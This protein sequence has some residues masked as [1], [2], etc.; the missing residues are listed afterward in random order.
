MN[1]TLIAIFVI[2]ILISIDIFMVGF[3]YGVSG[4]KIGKSRLIIISAIGN[5]IVGCA[6]VLGFMISNYIT[7]IVDWIAF[8]L[9]MLIGLYKLTDWYISRKAKNKPQNKKQTWKQTITLA[10]ILAIDGLGA[11]F[12]VGF[13]VTL[14]FVLGVVVVSFF[15]DIFLFRLGHTLGKKLAKK[16]PVELGWIPGVIFI[17]IA[18]LGLLL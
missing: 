7:N 3:S 4:T 8:G 15:C 10:V 5:V 14:W 18:V 13:G 6:L 9:F 16:S 11:G 1:E 17:L 2:V 12:V